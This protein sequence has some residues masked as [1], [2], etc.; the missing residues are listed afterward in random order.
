ME[1]SIGDLYHPT[2]LNSSAGEGQLAH[3]ESKNFFTEPN[4]GLTLY[5][6][7]NLVYVVLV[8]LINRDLGGPL[9]GEGSQKSASQGP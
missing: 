6:A 4:V 7:V 1:L 2:F 8:K 5:Q 3:R 9:L